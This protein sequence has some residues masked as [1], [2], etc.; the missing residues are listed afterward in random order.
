MAKEFQPFAMSQQ[1]VVTGGYLQHPWVP[2]LQRIAGVD[3]EFF[4][5][6]KQD[7]SLAAAL[8]LDMS[9][10]RPMENVSVIPYMA[11]LRDGK[12]DELIKQHAANGD[13]MVPHVAVH[14]PG[15]GREKQFQHANIPKVVDIEIGSMVNPVGT[16]LDAITIQCV[17][18]PRRGL[19]PCVKLTPELLVWLSAVSDVEFDI[20][21]KERCAKTT[22]H[23]NDMEL[24]RLE[25]PLKWRKRGA[26]LSIYRTYTCQDGE[27]KTVQR[28]LTR[29]EVNLETVN[30]LLP[31]AP[32]S[33]SEF[34][35]KKAIE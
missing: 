9:T 10:A 25:P 29:T 16:R 20:T 27:Q 5:L 24:P 21:K 15:K 35:R 6:S 11:Q 30:V 31:V 22:Q 34:I 12:V 7:R 33:M 17:P 14:V 4:T 23:Y 2:A 18:T 8:G 13:P 19:N 32:D 28:T 26:A 1:T 3:G